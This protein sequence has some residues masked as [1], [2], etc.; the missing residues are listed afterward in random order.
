MHDESAAFR[1]Q[2]A[3]DLTERS[4]VEV[5]QARQT[6]SS[7]W[8]G[9]PWILDL[10]GID[11]MDPAGR[12]L[13]ATWHGLGAQLVAATLD[14][15]M[16]LGVMTAFPIGLLEQQ[17]KSKWSAGTAAWLA[18]AGAVAILLMLMEQVR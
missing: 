6:A 14:A 10:T 16:R 3:G 15:R 7:I 2:L 18:T 13:I 1:F 5:D 9:R 12:Q 17:R 8:N 4:T 11:G